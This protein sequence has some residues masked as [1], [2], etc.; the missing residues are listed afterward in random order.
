M[1]TPFEGRAVSCKSPCPFELAFTEGELRGLNW[2][3]ELL[4]LIIEGG[5]QQ[6]SFNKA[7]NALNGLEKLE[8]H[9]DTLHEAIHVLEDQK[10]DLKKELAAYQMI[11][12]PKGSA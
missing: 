2:L 3:S 5:R 12:Q 8:N 9:C 10:E 1:W 7:V 11:V 6:K 4:K